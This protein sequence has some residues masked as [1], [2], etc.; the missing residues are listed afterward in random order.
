VWE[1]TRRNLGAVVLVTIAYIIASIVI[2]TVASIVGTILCIVGL[3]VTIPLGT[4]A[5]YLYQY[6]L[7]GQ[8]AYKDRTGTPYY[9]PPTP[10]AP[11]PPATYAPPPAAA[12]P[13]EQPA[14]PVQP[15]TPVSGEASGEQPQQ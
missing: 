11:P 2:S 10:V 7:I 14:A 15:D 3:I 8:L 4:L 6:H 12:A 1:W 13:G 5:T 9:V